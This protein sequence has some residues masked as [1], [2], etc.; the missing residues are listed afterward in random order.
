MKLFGTMEVCDDELHIG[1]VAVSDLAKEF[2]TPLYI[3]DEKALRDRCR[4]FLS[5][6]RSKELETEVIYASKAFLNLAMARLISEENM[7]LDV[8]S[9][10]EL[11]TA[12]AAGFPAERIYFHGNNKTPEEL[13]F[14]VD[15]KVGTI[16][17]DNRQ[18]VLHLEEILRHRNHK[19]DVLL[20]VNPGIEAHTHEYI[21]TTKNDSKFGVSVFDED[22]LHFIKDLNRSD[23]LHFKGL[24]C[25]VGSQIFKEDTYFKSA[26]ALLDYV[27]QLKE[28]AGIEIEKL[29]LGGGFGIFYTDQDRPIVLK[30][31]L[32]KLLAHLANGFRTRN[33]KASKIAIEPGRSIV[34]NA[35]STLYT[36]GGTKKTFAGR[37]YLFVDGGMTDNIRP[38]LYRAKY[39][40]AVANKM[41]R[42]KTKTYAVGG[43]CC[44]SADILI[45]EIDLPEVEPGDL[46]LVS[47]TGAYGYSMANNYNRIEKPAV[48]FVNDGVARLVVRRE[49]YEDLIRND[50]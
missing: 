46:F 6:F 28:K 47:S 24:H 1:S 31:F 33:L 12:L 13:E 8:V 2:K 10:G 17:L 7:S 9:G 49:T 5:G 29:N 32:P 50:I 40:G 37:E 36:I 21:L 25:H 3:F 42:K 22:T 39:E 15:E 11:Y 23:V 18:E 16:V 20:R 26:D 38:A 30:D 27:Q 19:Q 14:A 43:K 4:E 41:H 44:E 48:V 34:G 45:D 35:G